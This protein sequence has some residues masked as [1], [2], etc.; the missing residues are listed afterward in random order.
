V[1]GEALTD[2]QVVGFL[3][4]LIIAGNETTTKLLGNCLLALSASGEKAK[5]LADR[6]RIP[7]DRGDPA[8]RGSTQAWHADS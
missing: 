2:K 7:G 8:F 1:D 6:S 4:L 5:V 3:F